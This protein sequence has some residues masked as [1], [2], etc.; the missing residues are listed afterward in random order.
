MQPWLMRGLVLAVVNGA[1]QTLLG[2]IEAAHP[3]SDRV[4]EPIAIAVLAGIALL[5]SAIDGWLRKPGRG[6]VWFFAALIGGFGAGLLGVIGKAAFVDSTG[7]WALGPAL[8]GGAAFTAL[9]ILIPA[10]LGLAVGGK[11]LQPPATHPAPAED[12]DADADGSAECDLSNEGFLDQR[13]QG[14]DLR[15]AA[16]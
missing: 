3:T 15:D 4:A 8:T 6:M 9:L 14:E 5:W 10:G 1:A 12:G 16:R 2:A 7:I 13:F 11:M